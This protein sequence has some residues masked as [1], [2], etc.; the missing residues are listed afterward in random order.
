M[1]K[2]ITR[3]LVSTEIEIAKFENGELVPFATIVEDKAVEKE[4]AVKIANRKYKNEGQIVVT[5]VK[6]SEP[7]RRRISL[8]DFMKYSEVIDVNS[9]EENEEVEEHTEQEVSGF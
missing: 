8:E 2:G 7:Q 1:A 5:D 9:P 6:V 4:E 3:T